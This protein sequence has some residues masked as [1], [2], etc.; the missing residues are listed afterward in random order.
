MADTLLPSLARYLTAV[1]KIPGLSFDES[2][3][4]GNVH[5]GRLPQQP[6]FVVSLRAYG[7]PEPDALLGYTTRHIQVRVRGDQDVRTSGDV[8][9]AIFEAVHGLNGV[10]L[11]SGP[12]IVLCV[13]L[14]AP[15]EM[16]GADAEG[17]LEHLVNLAIEFRHGPVGLRT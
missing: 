3:S 15:F 7:G 5:I 14:Q 17:R 16:D 2:G 8:A 11:P 12:R 13:A 9:W 10:T 1:A 6:D 4:S